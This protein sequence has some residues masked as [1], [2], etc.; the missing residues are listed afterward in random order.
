MRGLK[1]SICAFILFT[2]SACSLV[3]EHLAS[4]IEKD[5]V[6]SAVAETLAAYTDLRVIQGIPSTEDDFYLCENSKLT[7]CTD[8]VRKLNL[9]GCTL[10]ESD[11]FEAEG[12]LSFRF[13]DLISCDLTSSAP[14]STI[15]REIALTLS[16]YDT[17]NIQVGGE[18]PSKGFKVNASDNFETQGKQILEKVTTGGSLIYRSTGLHRKAV[19]KTGVGDIAP[20]RISTITGEDFEVSSDGSGLEKGTVILYNHAVKPS[21]R[22]ELI[23]S[24]NP[25]PDTPDLLYDQCS[26]PTYGTLTGTAT[27]NDGSAWSGGN[28]EMTIEF[29]DC[30]IANFTFRG[31]THNDVRLDT[32]VVNN[33]PD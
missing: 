10:G 9:D 23:P 18:K 7:A 16:G 6:P 27:N 19:A 21:Y 8:G 13:S 20:L 5:V 32:C 31:E 28:A 11:D 26:C 33:I 3:E 29:V 12:E 30:G 25:D 22:V 24:P 14:P 17:F 1:L 2:T 15:E 4:V